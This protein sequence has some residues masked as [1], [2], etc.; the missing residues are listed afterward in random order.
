MPTFGTPGTCRQV[1]PAGRS[2][3]R[4]GGR[5]RRALNRGVRGH[6]EYGFADPLCGQF[7]RLGH[8]RPGTPQNA[9]ER[10]YLAARRSAPLPFVECAQDHWKSWGSTENHRGVGT[11]YKAE[12]FAKVGGLTGVGVFTPAGGIS[13]DGYLPASQHVLIPLLGP[14][15]WSRLRWPADENLKFNLV[16]LQTDKDTQAPWVPGLQG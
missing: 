6:P 1:W 16:W 2:G 8:P 13:F 4:N 7:G 15:G 9:A 11:A 14:E 5:R 3:L 10:L 12:L